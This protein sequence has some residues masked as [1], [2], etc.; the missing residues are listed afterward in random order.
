MIVI[1][2]GIDYYPLL[3]ELIFVLLQ[4]TLKKSSTKFVY[5]GFMKSIYHSLHIYLSIMLKM[6]VSVVPVLILHNNKAIFE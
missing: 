4:I 6:K 2:M 5:Y 3:T 1:T